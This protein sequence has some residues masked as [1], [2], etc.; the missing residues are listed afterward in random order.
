MCCAR[1]V[2]RERNGGI[3]RLRV[4]NCFQTGETPGSAADP[5]VQRGAPPEGGHGAGQDQEGPCHGARH[6]QEQGGPGGVDDRGPH[7]GARAVPRE[8]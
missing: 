3:L 1:E 6:D 7:C 4:N 8:L 2:I 5:G